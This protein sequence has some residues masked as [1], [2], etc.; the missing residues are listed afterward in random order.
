[1]YLLFATSAHA[2]AGGDVG[3]G[4]SIV[5]YVLMIGIIFAIFYFLVIR[6]QQKQQKEHQNMLNQLEKG[7]RVV[8]AGGIHGKITSVQEDTVKL[9]VAKDFKLTMNKSSISTVKGAT[10]E[11]VEGT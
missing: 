2:M 4:N 7:N 5:S 3:G 6:P 10:S 1:M 9:Q 11:D 8:T